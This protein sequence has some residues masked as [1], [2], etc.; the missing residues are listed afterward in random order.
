MATSNKY[1]QTAQILIHTG[2]LNDKNDKN[3]V[4][5]VKVAKMMHY[6][7]TLL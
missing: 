6:A 1:C 5:G 2:V 4:R 3:G 7:L